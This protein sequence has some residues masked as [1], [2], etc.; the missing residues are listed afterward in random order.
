[1][2]PNL[3]CVTDQLRQ[4]R[5]FFPPSIAFKVDSFKAPPLTTKIIV[6][7]LNILFKFF[8]GHY[9]LNSLSQRYKCQKKKKRKDFGWIPAAHSGTAPFAKDSVGLASAFWGASGG[10]HEAESPPPTNINM[11]LRCPQ[12]SHFPNLRTALPIHDIMTTFRGEL[13]FD[14]MARLHIVIRN[15]WVTREYTRPQP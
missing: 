10:G 2:A 8:F 3:L 11:R 12:R 13:A 14:S 6:E 9:F 4:V 5:A 1:M 15:F 7:S